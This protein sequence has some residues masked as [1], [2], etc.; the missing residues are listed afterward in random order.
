M[1]LADGKPGADS[2]FSP[3]YLAPSLHPWQLGGAGK[4]EQ[5]PKNPDSEAPGM[6]F[7]SQSA[8]AGPHTQNVL[9]GIPDE[10]SASATGPSLLHAGVAGAQSRCPGDTV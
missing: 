1:C 2:C 7:C 10:T 8:W 9:P 4:T 3:G 6:A 5:E